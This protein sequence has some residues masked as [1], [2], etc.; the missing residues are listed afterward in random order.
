MKRGE[1]GT[2]GKTTGKPAMSPQGACRS[3]P[4]SFALDADAMSRAAQNGT[5]VVTFTNRMQSLFALNWARRLQVVGLRS[6][7]GVSQQ[8]DSTTNEAMTDA[9][10]VLFCAE[11]AN[12]MASN[13]QAGRWAE[14][15]PVLRMARQLSLSVLLSDSDI[16]WVR[17]PLPY[18]AAAVASHPRLDLLMMT[19]RAFNGYSHAPL[20]IQPPRLPPAWS[21]RAVRDASLKSQHSVDLELEPGY[22]SS[23][24]Y[25][26]GVI[27]F[28]SHALQ[29]HEEMIGRWVVSV[30]GD[31]SSSHSRRGELAS[32]DQ[33]PINKKVLQVGLRS[34]AEDR[35]LVRVDSGRL[36]MGVLPMLQ[37]T[38]AFTYFMHG[39]RR[40]SLRARPYCVHAIFAHGK[41]VDRKVAIFREEMLWHDPPAYYEVPRGTA[42]FLVGETALPPSLRAT[43]GF[44]MIVFQL[45][46]VHM[47]FRLAAL[48]NR[49]LVLPRLRCGER[50][51]AYPCYAWYHRAMAYFGLNTD[52]VPMPEFCPMYYWLDLARIRQLPVRTREPS[53]LDNP[54]TPSS[55]RSSV[56]R[57]RFCQRAPCAAGSVGSNAA[58]TSR[59]SSSDVVHLPAT[60]SASE[61]IE[62]LNGVPAR[63]KVLRVQHVH[64]LSLLPEKQQLPDSSIRRDP[65][66]AATPS[67]LPA[68]M[69]SKSALEA[70]TRGFWCTA[71]PVTRRGAVISELNRSVVRELETFCKTEARGRLGRGPQMHSCCPHGQKLPCHTCS[72]TERRAV[73]ESKLKWPNDLWI[74]LYASLELPSGA[75][76]NGVWPRC[77]HP[78]CTGA[79]RKRFP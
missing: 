14:A 5:V 3:L 46:Q 73:N 66:M 7:V 22:E 67:V 71:C 65:Q 28:L 43:G 16:A 15:L 75:G 70:V 48:T 4:P 79:D 39:K 11:T 69:P 12:M 26:I 77:T 13:G 64:W 45:R 38:T 36:A 50:P 54:R 40:E 30:G 37:F 51:M 18:F 23:I 78:L 49:T 47:L 34:D 31:S 55:I 20:R 41:D 8:L 44:D 60:A 68:T 9:G 10:A 35:R 52:K 33:E 72:S 63:A 21:E 57:L 74:P 25:N 19:D 1:K 24:S 29:K 76:E 17:N 62:A 59:T 2:R 56:A 42:G 27:L 6:L 53:F 61:L 32:W 58:S